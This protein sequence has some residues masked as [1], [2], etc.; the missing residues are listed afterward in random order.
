ME[1]NVYQSWPSSRGAQISSVRMASQGLQDFVK[2]I[3][4]ATNLAMMCDRG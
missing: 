3:S 2:R 1:W 4:S